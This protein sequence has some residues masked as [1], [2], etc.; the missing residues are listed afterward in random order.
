MMICIEGL[1]LVVVVITCRSKGRRQGTHAHDPNPNSLMA[2]SEVAR[3]PI[4][5]FSGGKFPT[6]G[7]A[8]SRRE[9]VTMSY[10][11]CLAVCVSFFQNFG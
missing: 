3:G 11:S 5:I 9:P 4:G 2:L 10:L 1:K 8:R 7:N 6:G